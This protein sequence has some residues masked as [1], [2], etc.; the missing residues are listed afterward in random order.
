[1]YQLSDISPELYLTG[2]GDVLQR[3]D[4][5]GLPLVAVEPGNEINW[6]AYDGDL[7]I[8]PEVNVRTARSLADPSDPVGPRR[9]ITPKEYS[10]Q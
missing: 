7:D 3:I 6:G 4:R 2:I 10:W 9:Q 5:V 8:L 1:M